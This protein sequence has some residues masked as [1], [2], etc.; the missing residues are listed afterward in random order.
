MKKN[1]FMMP[2]LCAVLWQAP[3]RAATQPE[4]D[5]ISAMGELNG[6]ALQCR[7]I[8]RVQRIKLSLVMHLPK[9]R[10]LGEWFEHTTNNSFIDF[11][12]KGSACPTR[13][14]F[15][16]QLDVAIKQI[17]TTFKQ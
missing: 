17:E 7:Y 9:Q 12:R 8:E 14:Q 11:M 10:E 4:L 16:E 2:L 15:D 13:A 3:V 5:A 1:L 6:I